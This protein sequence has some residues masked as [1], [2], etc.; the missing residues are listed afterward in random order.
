MSETRCKEERELALEAA[1]A[2]EEASEKARKYIVTRPLDP[3]SGLQPKSPEYLEEMTKAY[4][5]EAE[6]REK[7]IQAMNAWHDCEEEAS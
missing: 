5:K 2:W 3:D 6:A 4:Q 1:K 7:Y